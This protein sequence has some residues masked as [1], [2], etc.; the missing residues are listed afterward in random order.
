ME[1]K[2]TTKIMNYAC[3]EGRRFSYKNK[4]LH[5]SIVSIAMRKIA[6]DFDENL[7]SCL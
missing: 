3:M 6:T 1:Y 7:F 5:Q 4:F 2:T